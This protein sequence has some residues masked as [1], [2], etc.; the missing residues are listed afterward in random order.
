MDAKVL[1]LERLDAI[2]SK[3]DFWEKKHDEVTQITQE[4]ALLKDIV[5]SWEGLKKEI[6]DL[7]ILIELAVEEDDSE[8]IEE[9]KEFLEGD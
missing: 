5:D 8:T 4:R 6:D 9:I 2:M 7:Y 3:G 1:E